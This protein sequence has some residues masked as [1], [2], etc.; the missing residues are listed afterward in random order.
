[1]ELNQVTS[2]EGSVPSPHIS[3]QGGRRQRADGKSNAT[4]VR[5]T[6]RHLRQ[7]HQRACHSFKYRQ[8][9]WLAFNAS[10]KCPEGLPVF[11]SYLSLADGMS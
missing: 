10:T 11:E 5:A 7:K 8:R 3:I 1:M 4:Q 2:E 6:L 9:C